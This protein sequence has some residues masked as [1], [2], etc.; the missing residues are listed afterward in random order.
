MHARMY[1]RTHVHTHAHI[2]TQTYMYVHIIYTVSHTHTHICACKC[3]HT[4]MHGHTQTLRICELTLIF[5]PTSLESVRL[6]DVTMSK[7]SSLVILWMRSS[8]IYRTPTWE[9]PT[10]NDTQNTVIIIRSLANLT[11]TPTNYLCTLIS[12]KSLQICIGFESRSVVLL[13]Q[14]LRIP[15]LPYGSLGLSKV[16]SFKPP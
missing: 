2:H 11:V 16:P 7:F 15:L 3:A 6:R 12:H 4:H 1:A 14:K 13:M 9:P 8:V 5:L 10:A